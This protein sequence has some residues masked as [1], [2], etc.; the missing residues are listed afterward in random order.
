MGHP[1]TWEHRKLEYKK[2]QESLALMKHVRFSG[3]FISF[4]SNFLPIG[5]F[6]APNFR[7]NKNPILHVSSA[8]KFV[9][10]C[11]TAQNTFARYHRAHRSINV[12]SQFYHFLD[13]ICA[14]LFDFSRNLI[15][16]HAAL[17]NHRSSKK[18]SALSAIKNHCCVFF[19]LFCEM[20][21]KRIFLWHNQLQAVGERF[22]K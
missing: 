14:S 12:V 20:Q 18:G 11:Q 13:G 1:G 9:L 2:C 5:M 4:L 19:S 7:N 10:W 21:K 3:G 16:L 17:R 22:T 15:A 6:Y 8:H